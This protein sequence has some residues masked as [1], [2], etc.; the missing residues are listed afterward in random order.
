MYM[1]IRYISSLNSYETKLPAFTLFPLH[2]SFFAFVLYEYRAPLLLNHLLHMNVCSLKGNQ[3][4]EA[5][6]IVVTVPISRNY[7]MPS[8]F[9]SAL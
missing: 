6:I 7:V 4:L 2:S 8:W 3:P 1:Y 9:L 5:L